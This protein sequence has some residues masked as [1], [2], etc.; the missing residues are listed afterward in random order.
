MSI[1]T[2]TKMSI[3]ADNVDQNVDKNVEIVNCR[4]KRRSKCRYWQNVGPFWTLLVVGDTFGTTVDKNVGVNW[5]CRQKCRDFNRLSMKMSI[6][7]HLSIKMSIF[8]DTVGKNRHFYRRF[9]RQ[10]RHKSTFLST[11][12]AQIDIFIDV[13]IDNFIDNVGTNRHFYRQRR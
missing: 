1:K 3:C 6:L 11:M 7:T 9:D 13:L 12:S 4:W 5:H 2:S 8:A 10:C